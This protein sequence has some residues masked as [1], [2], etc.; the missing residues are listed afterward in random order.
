MKLLA[1]PYIFPAAPTRMWGALVEAREHIGHVIVNPGSGPGH[2]RDPIWLAQLRALETAE[3]AAVGYLDLSYTRKPLSRVLAEVETWR[4]WYGVTDFFL[5]CLPSGDHGRAR[6]VTRA[7]RDR[8]RQLL[9]NP[10]VATTPEVASHFD[11]LVT[12]EGTQPPRVGHPWLAA[13]QARAGRR[14]SGPATAWIH[15]D[16]SQRLINQTVSA[17]ATAGVSELW[18]TDLAGA[19]PYRDLP[20]YW[21][22]LLAAIAAS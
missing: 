12:Y 16:A 19:N 13:P 18:M 2:V 20:A 7:L 21:D 8:P 6:A 15:Y 4:K 17:A 3:L 10:G 14:A 9:A 1:P 22:D 5:D 11:L